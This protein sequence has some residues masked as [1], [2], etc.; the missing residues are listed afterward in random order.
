VYYRSLVR[1][2]VTQSIALLGSETGMHRHTK[3]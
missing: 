3:A 2:P 1:A